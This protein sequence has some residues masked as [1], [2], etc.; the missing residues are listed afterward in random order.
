MATT[1]PL[2]Q[3]NKPQQQTS[4]LVT[5]H[6][7]ISGPPLVTACR[8]CGSQNDLRRCSNCKVAYYCSQ[9]HQ[10]CDWRNHRVECKSIKSAADNNNALKLAAAAAAATARLDSNEMIVNNDGRDVVNNSEWAVNGGGAV[11]SESVDETNIG[12]TLNNL[13]GEGSSERSILI[14]KAESITATT[15]TTTTTSTSAQNKKPHDFRNLSANAIVINDINLSNP[16][17]LSRQVNTIYV[18][19]AYVFIFSSFQN[20][21]SYNASHNNIL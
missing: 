5:D 4:Q 6:N 7:N 15:T 9:T 21:S 13:P 12:G 19:G 1:N 3:Q 10:Q 20:Y 16:N 2:H 18:C 17:V 11:V 8:V 14:D